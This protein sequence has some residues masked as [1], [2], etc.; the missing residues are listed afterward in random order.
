MRIVQSYWSK[1]SLGSNLKEGR[2][3]GGWLNS[4]YHYMS[5][6]L[7]CLLLKRYHKHVELITDSYGEDLLIKTLKLPYTAVNTS[8]NEL[9]DYSGALWALPKLYAYSR[10]TTPFLHVDGDVFVWKPMVDS[11]SIEPLIVQSPEFDLANTYKKRFN[12]LHQHYQHIPS[13]LADYNSQAREKTFFDSINAGV[14]GGNDTEFIQNYAYEAIKFFDKNKNI[15]ET[16]SKAASLNVIIEQLFFYKKAKKHNKSIRYILPQLGRKFDEMLQFHTVPL[17]SH[18]IHLAGITKQIKINC[19]QVELRL[20]YE[21]PVEYKMINSEIN[22]LLQTTE[23][24]KDTRKEFFDKK[25][26]RKKSMDYFGSFD[27]DLNAYYNKRELNKAKIPKA[28]LKEADFVF[29]TQLLNMEK[30]LASIDKRVLGYKEYRFKKVTEAFKLLENTSPENIMNC[31]LTLAKT[32]L[33]QYSNW[34]IKDIKRAIKTKSLLFDKAKINYKGIYCDESGS[35][36]CDL[37]DMDKYLAIFQGRSL[38]GYQLVEIVKNSVPPETIQSIGN[39][40]YL[41]FHFIAV[42]LINY[43]RLIV[44]GNKGEN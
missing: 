43:G 2:S 10:Q 11:S 30:A 37:K 15:I 13:E 42:N 7:S 40:E 9:E 21:F 35:Y 28:G 41:V 17:L 31:E 1:P 8:L 34:S 27:I 20:K 12:H 38:T 14:F 5:L 19:E 26:H 6:S 3:S 39:I 23:Q 44:A 22:K 18:Y 25:I 16:D 29:L 4:R 33:V 36:A 32:F 24:T